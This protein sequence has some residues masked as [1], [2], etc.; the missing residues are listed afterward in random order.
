MFTVSTGR[1]GPTR[2]TRQKPSA[3]Y[4][5]PRELS[6]WVWPDL[7]WA[8]LSDQSGARSV[9]RI[10]TELRWDEME[11]WGMRTEDWGLGMRQISF[12]YVSGVNREVWSQSRL[13]TESREVRK[14]I[15]PTRPRL[16]S[17]QIIL[18]CNRPGQQPATTFLST[19]QPSLSSPLSSPVSFRK[20]NKSADWQDCLRYH[21]PV[22]LSGKVS[23]QGKKGFKVWKM[24]YNNSVNIFLWWWE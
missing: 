5:K 19:F 24:W 1:P 17:F 16:E 23:D 3:D 11:V 7:G 22:M 2:G 6:C 4:W 13:Q 14:M 9:L 15:E 10:V 8:G 12:N 21:S 18:W 20:T